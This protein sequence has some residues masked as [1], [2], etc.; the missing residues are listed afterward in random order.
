MR[1]IIRFFSLVFL[2]L[3]LSLLLWYRITTTDLVAKIAGFGILQI[4][5]GSMEKELL[6]GDIILI[7]E[8]DEYEINDVVTYCVDGRYLVTH[9]ITEKKQDGFVT[10]GDNNNTVDSQVVAK[11]KIEGKVICNLKWL[12]WIYYHWMIVIG[13]VLLSLIL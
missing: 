3:F 9:R 2:S 4:S 5:S 12:K 1:K 7:K 13:I 8:C 6:I 10:K 11:D